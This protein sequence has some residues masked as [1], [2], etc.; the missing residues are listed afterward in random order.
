MSQYIPEANAHYLHRDGGL[1]RVLFPN[2]N[3]T[4]DGT[5]AVVVY[6][7][8]FPFESKVWVRPLS[9]WTTDR[10]QVVPSAVAAQMLENDR[11]VAQ[12]RI[13]N[14]KKTRKG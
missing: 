11:E 4:T 7:H 12:E 2:A 13:I 6:L 10:F 5:E 14:A 9:E 8:L 3:L 1:Y